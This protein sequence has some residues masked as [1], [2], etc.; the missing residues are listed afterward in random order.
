[1]HQEPHI[2]F[3]GPQWFCLVVEA[4]CQRQIENVLSAKGYRPFVPKVKRWVSHAR[5]KKAV[6]RPL[7]GRYMFCRGRLSAPAIR[8]CNGNAG[9]RGDHFE[10]R[11]SLGDVS[12]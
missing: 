7:L 1:M 4:G 5:V 3:N 6:E 8:T 11:R 2:S 12:D 10:R 9:G